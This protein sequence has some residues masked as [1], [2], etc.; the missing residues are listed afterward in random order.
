MIF[1]EQTVSI[2]LSFHQNYVMLQN[3]ANFHVAVIVYCN[4]VNG[5][6]R[7]LPLSSPRTYQRQMIS[8]PVAMTGTTRHVQVQAYRR[9]RPQFAA[10]GLF[11]FL[12]KV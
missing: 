6:F 3:T 8:L 10:W 2:K 7:L 4:H 11:H 12:S 1:R 9:Q 5:I